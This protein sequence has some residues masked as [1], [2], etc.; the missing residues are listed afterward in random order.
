M[1]NRPLRP[2]LSA[3]EARRLAC[4]VFWA[5]TAAPAEWGGAGEVGTWQSPTRQYDPMAVPPPTSV[6]G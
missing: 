2:S 4:G 3:L 1:R 6:A 5:A